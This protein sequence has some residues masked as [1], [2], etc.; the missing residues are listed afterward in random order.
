MSRREGPAFELDTAAAD[1][2]GKEQDFGYRGTTE[3][4]LNPDP[5]VVDWDGPDDPAN[6]LNWS[7]FKRNLHVIIVSIFTLYA[8]VV[9]FLHAQR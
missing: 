3:D 5:N 7:K 9:P 4:Q 2:E 6:P 1:P 8:S